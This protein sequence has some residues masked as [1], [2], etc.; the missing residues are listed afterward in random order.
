MGSMA[1]TWGTWT[2]LVTFS[3]AATPPKQEPIFDLAVQTPLK[4]FCSLPS[5]LQYVIIPVRPG[6]LLTSQPQQHPHQRRLQHRR[7]SQPA[8]FPIPVPSRSAH[9]FRRIAR[10]FQE[11]RHHAPF[12]LNRA[13]LFWPPALH[14]HRHTTQPQDALV[15]VAGF[16]HRPSR[17]AIHLD[18]RL[19][20]PVA[21]ALLLTWRR[22]KAP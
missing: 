1:G 21:V 12:P 22:R 11:R 5:L 14:L 10:Q 2:N 15:L 4:A 7:G 16:H 13:T 6:L 17:L 3:A 8:V 19:R 20:R 9:E 18:L